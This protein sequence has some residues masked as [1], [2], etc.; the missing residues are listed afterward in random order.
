M[1]IPNCSR[2]RP[3]TDGD[4]I[5]YE[6]LQTVRQ[7]NKKSPHFALKTDMMKAY[8]RID[9]EYLHACLSKMIL[10]LVGYPR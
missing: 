10:L 1:S 5:T 9:W 2:L 4:L 6:C 7:Q 3:I 8:D